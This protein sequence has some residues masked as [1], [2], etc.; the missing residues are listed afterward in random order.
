MATCCYI[1]LQPSEGTATVVLAGHPPP[2]IAGRGE[3]SFVPADAGMPLGVDP[4]ERY[5][6]TTVMLPAR[7]TLVLY[8]DGLVDQVHLPL[9]EGLERLRR[10]AATGGDD[11]ETAADS[12]LVETAGVRT[13]DDAALLLVS[14]TKEL[15]RE[16]DDVGRWFPCDA[17][18]A[19]AAR[20]FIGDVLADWSLDQ[21][22]IDVAQLLVSELVT[23][24]VMHTAGAFEMR[25]RRDTSILRVSVCDESGER[26]ARLATSDLER[27][28]GRGL[29]LVDELSDA[30]GV[31]DNGVG[32]IVWFELQL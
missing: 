32:K 21:E 30:W 10:A 31:D 28:S 13:H 7:G 22:R 11:L 4:A 15:G 25:V 6:E 27:P 8:T 17:G 2:V 19:G 3:A 16:A 12:I 1:E 20:R 24:A 14:L 5:A 26:P 9:H 23:N 18:S 29:V